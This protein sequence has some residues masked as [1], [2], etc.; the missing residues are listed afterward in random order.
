MAATIRMIRVGAHDGM[1]ACRDDATNGVQSGSVGT[2][3]ILCVRCDPRAK[4]ELS[5]GISDAARAAFRNENRG[6]MAAR[7]GC[8]EQKSNKVVGART[9]CRATTTGRD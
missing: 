3:L 1:S 5:M 7:T 2:R 8:S 4:G 9:A 6:G